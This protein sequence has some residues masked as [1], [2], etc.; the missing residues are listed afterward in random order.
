MQT[1][2][3]ESLG[4]LPEKNRDREPFHSLI[5]SCTLIVLSLLRVS[6]GT[7]RMPQGAE[8]KGRSARA[9]GRRRAGLKASDG[10]D[11]RGGV[12]PFFR[13]SSACITRLE[14]IHVFSTGFHQ[15]FPSF[16]ST[17][18]DFPD[19]LNIVILAALFLKSVDF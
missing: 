16:L 5:S 6:A 4:N 13:F 10:K 15:R 19:F 11:G 18:E 14:A 8:L 3:R 1:R 17:F 7:A 12:L 2:R 9:A